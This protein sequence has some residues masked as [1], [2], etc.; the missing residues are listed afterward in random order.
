[1]GIE[2]LEPAVED[3]AVFLTLLP[4]NATGQAMTSY[5]SFITGP[6]RAG[7]RSG[8]EQLHVVLIDNGRTRMLAD[9]VMREVLA[10]IRCG[11]CQNVCPVYRHIGGHSYGGVYAGPIGSLLGP[12][13]EPRT[14]PPDLPFVSTLCGACASVCPVRIDIPR[15]LLHLRDDAM[16][17]R[18][19]K[20][21]PHRRVQRF[22]LR[23]WAAAM[24][25]PARYA[26]A[27]HAMRL[28]W[29]IFTA[30]GRLHRLPR[31]FHGWTEVREIPV[32]A[33][34]T[35]RRLPGI[36]PRSRERTPGDRAS[37]EIS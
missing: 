2:K 21:L 27:S 20:P 34:R 30:G 17:G 23:V 36:R 3:L 9:P 11:A 24:A 19:E 1:M 22:G 10:C 35:F 15:A 5:V 32:P 25:G 7:D 26:V 4:R 37:R 28:A 16:A 14:S 13:L 6:R 8:P 18:T 31:P 29:R 12:G 33:K